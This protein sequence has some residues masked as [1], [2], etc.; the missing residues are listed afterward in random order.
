MQ[1]Q[2]QLPSQWM[3]HVLATE[4]DKAAE[5]KRLEDLL[6]VDETRFSY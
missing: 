2:N 1:R 6:A 5:A 4:G 3:K